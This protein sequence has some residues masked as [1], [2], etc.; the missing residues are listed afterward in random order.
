MERLFQVLAVGPSQRWG[1][2][3][4]F[5]LFGGSGVQLASSQ[6]T[7]RKVLPRRN[8]VAGTRGNRPIL[9]ATAGPCGCTRAAPLW[10]WGPLCWGVSSPRNPHASNKAPLVY[11]RGAGVGLSV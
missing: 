7:T 3:K 5:A 2:G 10:I 1:Q 8:T 11:C 6:E 4:G 9:K